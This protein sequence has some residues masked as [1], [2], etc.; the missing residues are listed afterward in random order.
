MLLYEIV[1]FDV[2]MIEQLEHFT[3][4][5][6]QLAEGGARLAELERLMLMIDLGELAN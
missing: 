4:L 3:L 2:F 6:A 1:W 5:Q